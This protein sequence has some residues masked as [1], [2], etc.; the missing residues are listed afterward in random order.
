LA[1]E[2]TGSRLKIAHYEQNTG[3]FNEFDEFKASLGFAMSGMTDLCILS[4]NTAK[5]H[6]NH[7]LT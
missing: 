2:W 7:T 3:E 1:R 6:T 4:M 5:T